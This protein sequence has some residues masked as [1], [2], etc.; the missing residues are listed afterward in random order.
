VRL[1]V[2]MPGWRLTGGPNH[3]DA[4]DR[5]LIVQPIKQ[6]HVAAIALLLDG[7]FNNP[8]WVKEQDHQDR[9]KHAQPAWFS[10][11]TRRVVMNL[12][13]TS[14]G[15]SNSTINGALVDHQSG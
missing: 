9:C 6:K 2:L 5:S 10:M 13:L 4:W 15:L 11:M 1:H 8:G 14:S 12:L 3:T 7:R